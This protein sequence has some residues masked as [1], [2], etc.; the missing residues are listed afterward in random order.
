MR[1][2]I[3]FLAK[4]MYVC[5]FVCVYVLCVCVYV[6]ICACVVYPDGRVCISILHEAKHDI[7]N[8]QEKMSEKWRPILGVIPIHSTLVCVCVCVCVC[9]LVCHLVLLVCF[10]SSYIR[11]YKFACLWYL[12][13]TTRHMC[14][15]FSYT[16][17]GG[18][19]DA[20]VSLGLVLLFMC[21]PMRAACACLCLCICQ[22][23]MSMCLFGFGRVCFVLFMNLQP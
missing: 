16:C 6:Y 21:V 14:F 4:R 17:A 10:Q 2:Q 7:Y 5:I 3:F 13:H 19:I 23:A 20:S 11:M 8:A 9:V 12:H 18:N 22:C 15:A 1:I